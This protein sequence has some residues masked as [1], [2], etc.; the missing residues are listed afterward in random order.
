M[1]RTHGAGE[2]RASDAGADVT[3]AGWVH[4]V[5]DHKGVVFVDLR[6]ASGTV[7]IVFHPEETPDAAERAHRELDREFCVLIHGTVTKRKPGTENPKLPTGEVEVRAQSLEVLSESRTPPFVIED[8]LEADEATR[9]KYRYLDL[10]RPVMQRILKL[11]HKLIREIRAFL[12]ARGFVEIETPVLFKATPEGARD[13]LVPS[14]LQPGSF[15]ALPQSPQILKQLSMVAGMERY[16]QIA[17]CF[18]DEDARADRHLEFTQLD[19]EMSFVDVDDVIG[20]TE[21]LYAHLWRECLGVEVPLPFPRLQYAEAVDRFGSD[22]VDLRFGM[23]LTDVDGVFRETE[24]GIF[25]RVLSSG[26]AIRAIA[27][28]GG[29]DMA[30][31]ELKRHEQQAMERGA[32]GLAWVILKENSEV[33]GPLKKVLSAAEREGLAKALGASPG[34]L[35]L[36]VADRRPVAN[37]VLGSL[38]TQLARERNLIP[39]GE[40]RFCWI[41]DYPF[42]EWSEEEKRW[43]PMHHPFTSPVEGWEELIDADPGAVRMKAYDIVLN[44]L[45]IASGSIRIHR[46]DD[47]RKIFKVLGIDERTAEERF[48]FLLEAFRFGPPP[49]G[50]IAPGIERTLMRMLGIDNIR[51]VI[52]YP[53]TG[54]GQDLMSGAP[55]PVDP[56][57]LRELGIKVVE[58]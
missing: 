50:G 43:E 14:R 27:V 55:T 58:P 35:V 2:L 48:G 51:E 52:A 25:K 29:G 21:Q 39:D 18:R 28:P 32:K 22:H 33:D 47:Q 9:L 3:L 5:R 53:K 37:T 12:D 49:H 23:E 56:K 17:R 15:Y 11:R 10:R 24:L 16:Y 20:L 46:P 36:I 34:D 30:H 41:V 8:D 38:R 6:D 4:H 44:G 54:S 26:G 57:Q 1:M 31:A 40:W 45:E 13:F 7:Q 42:F 19:L